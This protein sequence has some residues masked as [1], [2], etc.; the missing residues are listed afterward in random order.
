MRMPNVN[1][2]ALSGVVGGFFVFLLYSNYY[3]KKGA[4]RHGKQATKSE[5]A[6]KQLQ[7]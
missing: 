2:F 4:T 5:G 6:S 3:C 1:I 7:P